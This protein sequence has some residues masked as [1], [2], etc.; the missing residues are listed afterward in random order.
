M[1]FEA[2]ELLD[3]PEDARVVLLHAE[4]DA[5]LLNVV[6]P[7]ISERR[8]RVLVW[9]RPGDRRALSRR[10]RDFVDWMQ[11]SVDVSEFVPAYAGETLDR[12]LNDGGSIRWEGPPLR[13]LVPEY[14]PRLLA[15]VGDDEAIA[16][17]RRGPVVVHRPH[18]LAEVDRFEGLRRAAGSG[19]GI[20]WDDPVV[21]PPG[22]VRIIAEPLDWELAAA[23]SVSRE[24]HQVLASLFRERIGELPD[25]EIARQ[26]YA[27]GILRLYPTPDGGHRAL[28]HPLLIGDFVPA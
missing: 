20:I 24:G 13:G 3:A 22:A 10:A 7:A 27:E 8:L 18:D 28:P 15:D 21:V 25:H 12:A 11:E 2:R 16:T 4:R 1:C 14:V 23:C 26:L 6:R 17:M 9:L 5:E 19:F